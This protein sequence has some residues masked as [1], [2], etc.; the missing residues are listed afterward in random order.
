MPNP[1]DPVFSNIWVYLG[2]SLWDLRGSSP[3]DFHA[4][5]MKLPEDARRSELEVCFHEYVEAA[6]KLIRECCD[7]CGNIVLRLPASAL[8]ESPTEQIELGIE[9]K[10]EDFASHTR[11][12]LWRVCEEPNSLGVDLS[13]QGKA[14][15]EWSAPEWLI[16]K[17]LWSILQFRDEA[18]SYAASDRNRIALNR[19]EADL[20]QKIGLRLTDGILGDELLLLR[21]AEQAAILASTGKREMPRKPSARRTDTEI[22]EQ[23]RAAVVSLRPLDLTYE[24]MMPELDRRKLPIPGRVSWFNGMRDTPR[25]WVNAWQLNDSR[26]DSKPVS[27]YLGSLIRE[28]EAQGEDGE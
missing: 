18:A 10:I 24:Q 15:L 2:R 26:G 8:S 23:I 3:Y 11:R 22:R 25:T 20:R 5:I 14:H 12:W 13:K 7:R 4:R 27:Q 17:E 6:G 19:L 28:A 21:S 9:R 16:K 1:L